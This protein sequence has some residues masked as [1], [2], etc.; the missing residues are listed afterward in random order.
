MPHG[1]SAGMELERGGPGPAVVE[2]L[3]RHAGMLVALE[4]APD[5]A[6]LG[7]EVLGARA[8]SAARRLGVFAERLVEALEVRVL[9]ERVVED[10][11]PRA[12]HPLDEDVHARRRYLRAGT[13]SRGR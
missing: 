8:R 9:A 1:G 10:R 2:E 13:K 5:L 11:R 3:Q 7:E 4:L 6:R 12:A